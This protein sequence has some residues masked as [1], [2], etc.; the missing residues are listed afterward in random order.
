VLLIRFGFLSLNRSTATATDLTPNRTG[1]VRLFIIV[2][3]QVG[4][5]TI[6]LRILITLLQ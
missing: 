2:M 6:G 5:I 1:K 3:E 4:I